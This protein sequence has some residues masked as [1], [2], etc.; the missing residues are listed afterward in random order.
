SKLLSELKVYPGNGGFPKEEIVPKNTFDLKNKESVQ[1]FVKQEKFEFVVIGPE[2][3]LV[4]GITDWMDEISI[5]CFGPSKFCANL[6]GSKDF[7]KKLM[8]D[9]QVPNALDSIFIEKKFGSSGN[10]VVIEEFMEGEE[11]SIFAI[12]DGN[13]FLVLPAAQDHKRAHDGDKGPNTGGMGAYAP[14]P[15]LNDKILEKVKQKIFRPMLNGLKK[16]GYPYKGLLYAG[17]M[18]NNNEPKVVEFNARFGDPETQAIMLLLEDDL[19][20]IM[21]ESAN[22]KFTT[23]KLNFKKGFSTIVVLAAEGYPGEYYKGIEINLDNPKNSNTIIFHAG[24]QILK[25]KILSN[26]GRILGITSFAESL[27]QSVDLSY[28]Y[29]KNNQVKNTYYRKDIA[30]RAL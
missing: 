27:K 5:P 22:G 28:E 21:L 9:F 16:M 26:G 14:A 19:L 10:Q 20:Q 17:L 25:D 13:D 6:E 3:P 24:T 18:I 2:E 1:K 4:D 29:L 8:K 7:A 12:C 11:A 15:I 23:D 30:G